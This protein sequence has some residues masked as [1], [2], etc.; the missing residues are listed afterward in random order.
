MKKTLAT[1]LIAGTF[2]STSATETEHKHFYIAPKW[3]HTYGETYHN[4]KGDCG[5][6]IGL[7]IGYYLG[8]GFSVEID[9]TYE[10]TT[11]RAIEEESIEREDVKYLTTSF[12][13]TYTY[14]L[15]HNI[16]PFLK[17]GYE[18]ERE[19]IADETKHNTGW[20]YAVGVE[21]ELNE[22]FKLMIEYEK[23]TIDG[24]KGDMLAAGIVY[25]FDL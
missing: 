11:V 8:E 17:V 16:G 4:E 15:T 22:E 13:M 23:S 5:N 9:A 2:V 14:P 12:A 18:Y 7:D 21:Y 1:L 25:S 6:G 3:I 24:P 10:K 20:I 19:K